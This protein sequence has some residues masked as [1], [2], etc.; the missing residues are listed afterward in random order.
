[1]PRSVSANESAWLLPNDGSRTNHAAAPRHAPVRRHRRD[2]PGHRGVRGGR[3]RPAAAAGPGRLAGG[4]P[5][6]RAVLGPGHRLGQRRGRVPP[7]VLD[8]APGDH[9]GRPGAARVEQL[10]PRRGRVHGPLRRLHAALPSQSTSAPSPRTG[11]APTGRSATA[12]CCR[13]TRRSR[14]NCRSRGST[15]PGA[16]RTAT[17]TARTRSAATARSFLRGARKLGITAR[18]G[19]VAIPNG[20]F[21]NRPHCIYR[22]FCLQ[23]CKVNAKASPLISHIPD[24]LAHGGEIRADA[25]VS[26]I[27]VD[28]RTGRA[29]GVR[30][31]RGGRERVPA[32]PDGRRG[33]LLDRDA[34]AAAELRPPGASPTD[35][36]TTST[37][38]GAISWC[39]GHRRP[40]AGSTTRSGC[41]RR[42]RP[43]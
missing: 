20:R 34:A 41:T 7:P 3:F 39:R 13:T 24:A 17:R 31:F 4:R 28:E 36:A 37:R 2:R 16:T 35:C 12:T 33:R 6:R 43:R 21:G 15:G 29:T 25:M 30:Y 9:R 42:R 23:G 1:M 40:R 32:G 8:R 5:G 26:R 14:R 38:S 18:V 19:P 10:R 27:G 22:G 11:S